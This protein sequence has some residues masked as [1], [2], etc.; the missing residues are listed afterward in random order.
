MSHTVPGLDP[1]RLEN[2]VPRS[3]KQRGYPIDFAQKSMILKDLE[4]L[5]LAGVPFLDRF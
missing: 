4:N 1:K 2:G 5:E 3:Q